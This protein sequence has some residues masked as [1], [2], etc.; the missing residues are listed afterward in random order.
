[1][2]RSGLVAKS[3]PFYKRIAHEK[4]SLLRSPQPHVSKHIIRAFSSVLT[5][6]EDD[7]SKS[8]PVRRSIQSNFNP[9]PEHG[10]LRD[11]VRSFTKEHIE[12]QANEF[13]KR[14]EFNKS[15]FHSLNTDL[16]L[17]K[18]TLENEYNGVEMDAT[19]VAIVHEEISYSDPAFCLSYLAHEVL[20]CN[21][22][23]RNGNDA[24]KRRWFVEKDGYIGGMC[25]SE[26][27]AG[28]DVLGMTTNARQSQD[29]NGW[30]LN[31]QK[32]WITNG[33]TDGNTTGDVYLVYAKTGEGR[34]DISQFI[35]EKEM[36]G[37][38]L[39]QQIKD[40]L[41]MRASPTAE[42][43]FENVFVP[44]GN[45]VGQINAGSIC[46]MRNLEIE[47]VALAAM[48]IG[49]ARR[50]IDEMISYSMQR[51]A[52]GQE[53]RQ[54][55]QIQ[56][57]IAESYA[58][59]M[60]GK[61]YLYTVANSLDLNSA[62]NGLDADGVKLYC[63]QMSKTVADRAIQVMGGYGYVGEYNVERLWRDA[64]LLEIGGGTNESHHKNMVRD[65]CRGGLLE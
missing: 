46:M 64:K 39:G 38:N 3:Y 2:L 28:T 41:G 8:T 25:M 50:C 53:I 16:G 35:V 19:A 59:Y 5:P 9:M 43:V 63:A 58:E 13:N 36:K 54:F 20:F 12:P 31:G 23:G 30:I 34:L 17:T 56:K 11:V 61:T 57:M 44:N 49:I 40:K 24:Q 32:M 52:F 48:A 10:Q 62:G 27:N 60:A 55:G 7:P 42:L 33:T 26:P 29:G 1:M 14:E 4:L 21:N 45:L 15:L 6:H 47:R 22:L 18:L 37:F 51:K 65:L